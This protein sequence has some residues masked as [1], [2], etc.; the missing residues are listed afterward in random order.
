MT[1]SVSV[2]DVSTRVNVDHN[3]NKITTSDESSSTCNITSFKSASRDR[4]SQTRSKLSEDLAFV[5]CVV[6]FLPSAFS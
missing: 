5:M 1:I 6:S 2:V 4:C 3:F